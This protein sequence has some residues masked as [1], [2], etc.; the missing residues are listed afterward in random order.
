VNCRGVMQEVIAATWAS[1]ARFSRGV[2]AGTVTVWSCTLACGHYAR[3]IDKKQ[4]LNKPKKMLCR[5]CKK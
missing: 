3:K 2:V 5:T 4:G 1:D